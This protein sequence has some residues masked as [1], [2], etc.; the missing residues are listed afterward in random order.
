MFYLMMHSTPFIYGYIMS[1]IIMVKDH[2]DN[3]KGN[4]LPPHRLVFLN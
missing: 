1:D 4:P 2:S 3:K